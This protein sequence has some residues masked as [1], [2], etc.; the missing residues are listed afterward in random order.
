MTPGVPTTTAIAGCVASVISRCEKRGT[1]DGQVGTPVADVHLFA[2][3]GDHVGSLRQL[4]ALAMRVVGGLSH[5]L[6]V[7]VVLPFSSSSD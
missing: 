1:H 6:I 4:L 2:K 5:A 3:D 7:L